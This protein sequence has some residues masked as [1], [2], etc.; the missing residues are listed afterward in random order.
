MIASHAIEK[1]TTF[2]FPKLMKHKEIGF[3]VLVTACKNSTFTGTIVNV[4]DGPWNLGKHSES[5]VDLVDFNGTVEL[6]NETELSSD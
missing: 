5:W 1:S 4:G 3:V 6:K 2:N